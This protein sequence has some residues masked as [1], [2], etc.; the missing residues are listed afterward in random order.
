M[1]REHSIP[2]HPRTTR[3]NVA[4]R[5]RIFCAVALS[6]AIIT[7][8]TSASADEAARKTL[9]FLGNKN[10]APVLYIENGAPAGVANDIVRALAKHIP[11]PIEIRAM[12]WGEAQQLVA[13]GEADALI[14]INR[15]PEREKTYDFSAPLLES[16][17]SIFTSAERTGITG[18]SS[19]SGL[20]VGVEASGLPRQILEN[21]SQIILSIIPNFVDGFRQ[22]NDGVIDAVVAD[23]IVGSYVLAQN[24]IRDIR[25]IGEPV[26]ISSSAIAVKKG[27]DK[28]LGE[29]NNALNAIKRDGTYNA[30]LEAWKPREGIFYT[31][32]QISGIIYYWVGLG[33]LVVAVLTAL[34]AL[35]LTRELNARRRAEAAQR[36]LNRKLSAISHCRLALMRAEDEPAL[37]AKICRIICDTTGYPMAWVGYTDDAEARSVR[38]VACWADAD[39]ACSAIAGITWKEAECER[40]PIG[41]AIRSGTTRSAA[42]SGTDPLTAPWR[43]ELVRRGYRSCIALPLKDENASTFGVLTIYSEQS[44]AIVPDEIEFLEELAG[45]LAFG[46]NVLRVRNE[47]NRV[48]A[49]IRQLNQELENRVAERTSALQLANKELE[50]FSYSVS[51]DLRAPLRAING[52][53]SILKEEY[54]GLLDEEG[55]R[56]LET[57]RRSSSR[58]GQMIT[59]LLDFARMS[60][61]EIAMARLDMT[62]LTRK[63]FEEVRNS[64]PAQRAIA[65]HLGDLPPARGDPA[66][67]RQVLVN[68][69]SN[70]VKFTAQKDEAVIEVGGAVAEKENTYWVKDNGVG[71]DMQYVDK[72]FGVFQRLHDANDYEGTGIGLAIVRR[73]VLRHGGRVWAEAKANEGA[74]LYFTLP[75]G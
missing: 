15:T 63:A 28:L 25:P 48:E 43:E 17:F 39:Q 45:D 59:D 58:M 44:A 54:A 34:W 2:A 72:L 37:L 47:R 9:V 30:I 8:L 1:R 26:A 55:R 60:R 23:Y 70:A 53:A 65:L 61:R 18:I 74:S 11:E 21:D 13:N 4:I 49:E 19:L 67:I 62:A 73:I 66:M 12:D 35:V 52:F 40:S 3:I 51:H 22:L 42:D 41:A 33:A 36:Q 71:F 10:L 38:P 75:S 27:N 7:A 20:R 68:L 64:A 14:Q 29:I 6:A 5:N 31:R 32:E 56:Y 16:R 57:I 69:L 50:A 24:R 46:I